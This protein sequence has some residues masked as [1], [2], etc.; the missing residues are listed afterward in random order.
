MM[1]GRV[2]HRWAPDLETVSRPDA[3]PPFDDQPEQLHEAGCNGPRITGTGS[4]T[5]DQ[6]TI[7]IDIS[8]A[9][10][11]VF[12]ARDGSS[13]RL[14]NSAAGVA[15]L[16]AE[17]QGAPVLVVMEATGI[18]DQALRRGLGAAGI[19]YVRVN[20]GRARD[21]A[22]ASGRLA[23]TDSIDAAM[24]AAMG[25]ALRLQPQVQTGTERARLQ[26][27]VHRR[28]QLVA[29]RAMEK[30]HA[31]AAAPDVVDSI[32]EHLA[33]LDGAIAAIAAEIDALVAAC[34]ALSADNDRLRSAPGIGP[35]AA[36]TLMALLPELGQ[37]SGRSIAAL[38]GLAPL[39][40]DSGQWRGQRR[41]GPGRRRVR[42]ALYMAALNAARC[43]PRFKAAYQRLL[44]AG[45]PKKLALI[46]IARKLIIILNAMMKA[47]K[48]FTASA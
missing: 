47:Q 11:D 14:A 9:H 44:A 15:A 34:A 8:K 29:I 21:F 46:A 24:L 22:R 35:V 41:I 27:L 17:L 1:Q 7:G 38:A 16:A 6:N 18:Y 48:P 37:R 31:E 4:M 45:K 28:D 26:A 10:L 33:W 2:G 3:H 25:A 36:T 42:Q 12:D 19:A 32:A 40:R 43:H 13:R 30:N 39:N 20:P 5:L 23:K